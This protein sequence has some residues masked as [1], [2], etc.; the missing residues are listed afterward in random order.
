MAVY[1]TVDDAALAEFLTTYDVGT[2]L[3]FAGIAEGVGQPQLLLRTDQAHYI[4]T[5]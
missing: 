2:V 5:L 4:L 1:T 3:S